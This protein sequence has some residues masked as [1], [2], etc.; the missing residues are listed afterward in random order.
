MNIL[1][2]LT[3]ENQKFSTFWISGISRL[4]MNGNLF[5]QNILEDMQTFKWFNIKWYR[6]CNTKTEKI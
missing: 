3:E 6:N 2:K 5:G 4:F 1:K